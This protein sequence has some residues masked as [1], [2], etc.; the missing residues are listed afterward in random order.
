M[1]LTK[2]AR[3]VPMRF[4]N[5]VVKITESLKVIRGLLKKDFLRT[6]KKYKDIYF[7]LSLSLLV[8]INK[9]RIKNIFLCIISCILRNYYF[10]LAAQCMVYMERNFYQI[11]E[12]VL[13]TISR[14]LFHQNKGP[15]RSMA[16][17]IS[18]YIY[19]YSLY[20]MH[21]KFS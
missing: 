14:V 13:S 7:F 21:R 19:M 8:E 17:Y 1:Y 18:I 9:K 10:K 3:N 11:N 6:K 2:R 5:T 20:R 16:K 12:K 4:T 15:K